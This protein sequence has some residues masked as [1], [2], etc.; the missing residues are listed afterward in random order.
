MPSRFSPL[1]ATREVPDPAG[2]TSPFAAAGGARVR[3]GRYAARLRPSDERAGVDGQLEH[4]Q[5]RNA[6]D[7]DTPVPM[8][9]GLPEPGGRRS[10]GGGSPRA[11]RADAGALPSELRFGA[12]YSLP[13]VGGPSAAPFRPRIASPQLR[14]VALDIR[15]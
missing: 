10:T 2:V 5:G 14:R 1:R 11:H 12:R 15:G 7:L 6:T 9:S 13:G 8:L 4:V 3:C